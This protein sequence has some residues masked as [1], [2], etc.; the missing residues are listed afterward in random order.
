MTESTTRQ[1]FE[2]TFAFLTGAALGAAEL[3]F[4]VL[5]QAARRFGVLWDALFYALSGLVVFAAGQWCSGG[6]HPRFLTA[7]IA[8]GALCAYLLT[9]LRRSVRRSAEQKRE[10]REERRREKEKLRDKTRKKDEKI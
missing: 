9:P 1:L 2:L 7:A 3:P 8:G 5:R 10:R 4:Y 6:V